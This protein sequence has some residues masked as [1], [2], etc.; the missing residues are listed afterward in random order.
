MSRILSPVLLLPGITSAWIPRWLCELGISRCYVSRTCSGSCPSPPVLRLLRLLSSQGTW[1]GS[2]N[3]SSIVEWIFVWRRMWATRAR[4]MGRMAVSRRRLSLR[5]VARS[6]SSKTKRTSLFQNDL[7]QSS[8]DFVSSRV[9][10]PARAENLIS[11]MFSRQAQAL[12]LRTTCSPLQ[13][14]RD[15]WT[16]WPVQGLSIPTAR[17]NGLPQSL[18]PLCSSSGMRSS[19]VVS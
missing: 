11:V 2:Q 9:M 19:N 17:A 16:W 1:Q 14:R 6:P 7:P 15:V 3:M 5:M 4:P 8:K 18:E 12:A 13:L 10:N